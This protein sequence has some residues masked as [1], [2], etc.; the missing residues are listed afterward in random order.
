M[1]AIKRDIRVVGQK[2]NA[3]EASK[4]NFACFD[5]KQQV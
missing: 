4:I 3:A 1:P 2:K 5:A